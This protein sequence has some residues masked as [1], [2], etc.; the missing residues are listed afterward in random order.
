MGVKSCKGR[1]SNLKFCKHCQ[2][3][4]AVRSSKHQK[5]C[6]LYSEFVKQQENEYE[7]K[8]CSFK[9]YKRLKMYK[10]IKGL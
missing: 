6:K 1:R 7:C 8:I 5:L 9:G 2:E 4:F 3:K 10:H